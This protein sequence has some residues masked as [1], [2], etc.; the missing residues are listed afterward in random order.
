M[1][2]KVTSLC[3]HPHHFSSARC[4]NC[5]YA[6][7]TRPAAERFWTKVNRNGP[8]PAHR[9]DLGQCWLWVGAQS[10]NSGYG[11]FWA[12]RRHIGAHR[13]AYEDAYGP[14]PKGLEPDHLCFVRLCVRP[15]HMEAVTRAVNTQRGNGPAGINSRLTHCKAGHDL[16]NAR[17]ERGGRRCRVCQA[18]RERAARQ[19][20]RLRTI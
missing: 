18:A 9:P 19:R 10:G 1:P 7:K 17:L 6:H 13:W 3:P 12:E 8:V 20:K 2:R 16:A 11:G 14:I 15:S 5:A 4:A